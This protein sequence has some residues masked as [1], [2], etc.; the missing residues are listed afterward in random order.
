MFGMFFALY[1]VFYC[2]NP[3]Y[4]R[5]RDWIYEAD[6]DIWNKEQIYVHLI[7]FCRSLPFAY[8]FEVFRL[9]VWGGAVLLAY[10]T[11]RMY[12]E[13]LLPGMTL[14]FL[15]VFYAGTFSYARASLAMA[16]YFFGVALYL[17][18]KGFITKVIGI[19]V[20]LSSMFFH[21]EL[22]I[23]IAVLPFLLIP[24][25]KKGYSVLAVIIL[26]VTV[27][28]I[29]YV[30]TNLA[31]F[32]SMLDNDDLI[33]K[34]DDY[35]DV[36]QGAFRLSTLVKYFNFIYPLYVVTRCYRR[37]KPPLSVAGIYRLSYAIILISVAFA[38][39]F[40]LR[41]IF[42]YRV[43]YIAMISLA[44]SIGY[45]YCNGYLNKRQFLIMLTIA[46]LTNSIRFIN[47][48]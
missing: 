28:V 10:C 24:F 12:R 43:I 8:P 35:N 1:A 41:S 36:E 19:G 14:L 26:L 15:F 13:Q 5:Y 45:C 46:L 2:I 25:E 30:N 29:S 34:I 42:V 32:D 48:D 44:F 20:A 39:V 11:F 37:E 22:V 4:F 6:F 40:G 3:D 38:V 18:K 23:G 21:Q 9:I 27:V 7:F 16:V 33:T 17:Q 31:I 47:A